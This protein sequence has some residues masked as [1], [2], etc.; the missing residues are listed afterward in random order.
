MDNGGMTNIINKQ[1]KNII[2]L[3]YVVPPPKCLIEFIL[4]LN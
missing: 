1:T 2:H 3:V 4:C